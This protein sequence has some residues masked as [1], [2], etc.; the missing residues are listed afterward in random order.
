MM[1]M[2]RM[3]VETGG[4]KKLMNEYDLFLCKYVTY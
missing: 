1:F 2:M 3:V 4:N